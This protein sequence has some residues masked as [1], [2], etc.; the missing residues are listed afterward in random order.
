MIEHGSAGRARAAAA[1]AVTAVLQEGRSLSQALPTALRPLH[2]SAERALAQELTYGTLRYAHQLRWLANRLL[3]HPLKSRDADVEALL[4]IGLYQ[5][6]LLQTPSH[7]AVTTT[8]EACRPL[9]KEWACG[10]V[11]AVLRAYDRDRAVHEEA[12]VASSVAR[13]SHPEWLIDRLQQA[14]SQQWHEILAANNERPPL[15][16]RVNLRRGTREDYQTELSQHH[17]IS[18]AGRHALTALYLEQPMDVTALPGFGGGRCSA[19][20]EAA[21]LA[22]TLLDL[23]PGQYVL[24]AC[25]AP[26]GKTTHLLEMEPQL[27]RAIALDS[28]AARLQRLR[29]NLQRL[30]LSCEILLA[31]AGNPRSWWDGQ[32]FDRILLDAPCSATGVIRRHPD[33]KSLRRPADI[34]ALARTQR[35]FLHALWPLLAHGGKLLYATCSILPDENQMQ[36]QEFLARQ[37]DARVE[38]WPQ[39][40]WGIATH[41]GRQILPGNDQMDGFYYALLVKT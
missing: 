2:E 25:A 35:Q 20:D 14:W 39:A 27:R 15:C 18:H 28:D 3:N 33:I 12:M 41:P 29:E 24:D 5:L 37:H 8:V 11:N 34:S 40:S 1:R 30:Q 26:G 31:D 10:L 16:L 6:R 36:I 13:Y 19:Q 17:I 21:Q 38:E 32:H 9:D 4:L 22:A 7:V 23:Q